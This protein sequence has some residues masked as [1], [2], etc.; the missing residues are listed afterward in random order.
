MEVAFR[1]C[2]LAVSRT[3]NILDKVLSSCESP[4]CT[5]PA[6]SPARN[7]TRKI[8]V[9]RRCVKLQV[10]NCTSSEP[11]SVIVCS[12]KRT[13]SFK[14]LSRTPTLETIYEED[15]G[16]NL[17]LTDPLNPRWVKNIDSDH[18]MFSAKASRA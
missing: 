3:F 8:R 11:V 10:K 18:I 4:T 9:R 6:C 7:Y 1:I 12:R 15:T 17:K 16:E 14:S 5:A 2:S 13:P